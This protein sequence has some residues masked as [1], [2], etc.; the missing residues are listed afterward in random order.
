MYFKNTDGIDD[1]RKY[2]VN[3]SAAS[4]RSNNAL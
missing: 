3:K 1:K 4:N 2:D